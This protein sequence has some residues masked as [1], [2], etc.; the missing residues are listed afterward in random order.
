MS[1]GF[2]VQTSFALAIESGSDSMARAPGTIRDAI[3][4]YLSEVAAREASIQDVQA[5]VAKKLGNVPA[6]SIRS[7]LN[8][9]VPGQ[10][11]RTGRGRYRLKKKLKAEP[12]KIEFL[13]VA[14]NNAQLVPADCFDWL[15][16]RQPASIHAVVTDPPYG[17]VEYTETEQIKLRNGRGGVWRIPP[18]FDGHKRAPLP[19]FTVLDD[20]DRKELQLFFQRLGDSLLRVVVPGANISRR[21]QPAAC[22]Y[23]RRVDGAERVGDTRLHFTTDD[24][25]ARRRPAEKRPLGIQR[26]ERDAALDVG[27]LGVVAQAARRPRAG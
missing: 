15:A 7:Y 16:Q 12:E 18:S 27:A 19:R 21:Q 3:L 13:S 25:H 17:L 6:S 9:N 26:R 14:H 23:R 2:D 5:A 24:D 11:E 1:A 4:A 10:F 20:H 8:L 22:A